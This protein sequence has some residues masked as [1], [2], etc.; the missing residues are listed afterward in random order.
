MSRHFSLLVKPSTIL[1]CEY[2]AMIG[3][4]TGITGY[5]SHLLTDRSGCWGCNCRQW[6]IW[7]M[8]E[9][10]QSSHFEFQMVLR[11]QMLDLELVR[12]GDSEV[13]GEVL[14]SF[15]FLQLVKLEREMV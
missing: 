2:F 8:E 9:G 7:A 3:G 4:I 6:R 13:T 11:Q 12:A 1:D 10:S 5:N 15:E 14:E